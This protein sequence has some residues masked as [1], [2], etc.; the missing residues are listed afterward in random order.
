MRQGRLGRILALG[1][2]AVMLAACGQLPSVDALNPFAGKAKKPV[3]D[4][5]PVKMLQDADKLVFYRSGGGRDI[6]D[7]VFQAELTGFDGECEYIRDGKDNF[8]AVNLTLQVS[9]EV[10]RGPA[11]A[12]RNGEISYFVAIPD[13]FPRAEGRREFTRKFIF[14]ENRNDISLSDSEIDVRL[15]LDA[16]RTGPDTDI[17]I[18][19]VLTRDQ[20]ENNRKRRANSPLGR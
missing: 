10:T 20:L 7:I 11:S 2:G 5:P 9:F 15:P 12:A 17:Y 4:C 14:P 3:P 19:F 18:G 8:T 1:I 6:T 16:A 13:F